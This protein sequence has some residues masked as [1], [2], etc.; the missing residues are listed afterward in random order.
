[1]NKFIFYL[2]IFFN[3]V[4][5]ILAGSVCGDH[6]SPISDTTIMSSAGAQCYHMNHVSTQ[7]QYAFVP[8]VGCV[9]GYIVAGYTK[10]WAISLLVGLIVVLLE[11]HFIKWRKER[12]E[13][14]SIVAS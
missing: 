6:V 10:N 11:I 2:F 4:S 8:L 14:Q 1:M 3:S 7:M 12:R 13:K 9:I 5:A